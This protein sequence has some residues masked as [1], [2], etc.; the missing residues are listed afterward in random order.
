MGLAPLSSSASWTTN[1][2]QALQQVADPYFPTRRAGESLG[3]L[4]IP[5]RRKKVERTTEEALPS[6]GPAPHRN[7]NFFFR[8]RLQ[9]R[10]LTKLQLQLRALGHSNA[11]APARTTN[12][13]KNPPSSQLVK[14]TAN[15]AC[16]R[17]IQSFPPT[18]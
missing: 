2:E 3:L 16:A 9:A 18:N 4:C 14:T 8:N 10:Q 17:V 15:L 11:R 12:N 5:S 7:P 1:A 6:K 13:H